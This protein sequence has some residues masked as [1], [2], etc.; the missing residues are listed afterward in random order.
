MQSLKPVDVT[1]YFP[2]V[3]AV[4]AAV[5][6]AAY[7]QIP[8]RLVA[9]A[10]AL[11]ANLPTDSASLLR[12]MHLQALLLLLRDVGPCTDLGTYTSSSLTATFWQQ[13][14]QAG[15]YKLAADSM[16]DTAEQL[17][18]A[19]VFHGASL[20][21]PP[22]FSVS[23]G[24]D[25]GS[26]S[27]MSFNS[28]SSPPFAAGTSSSSSS[29]ANANAAAA[30]GSAGSPGPTPGGK[31]ISVTA[32]S[33]KHFSRTVTLASGLLQLY[34]KL[35]QLCMRQ[36]RETDLEHFMLRVT[37]AACHLIVASMQYISSLQRSTQQ[38]QQ[39]QQEGSAA[40]QEPS[41]ICVD[42]FE[43]CSMVLPLITGTVELADSIEIMQGFYF[44]PFMA[45]A[46]LVHIYAELAQQHTL[47]PAAQAYTASS[48]S[49]SR[50]SKRS[51]EKRRPAASSSTG[52]SSSSSSSL[53]GSQGAAADAAA[54]QH[55]T[56]QA[57]RGVAGQLGRLPVAHAELAALLGCDLGTVVWAGLSLSRVKTDPEWMVMFCQLYYTYLTM[58]DEPFD[59]C[60]LDLHQL[61]PTVLLYWAAHQSGGVY[62]IEVHKVME[63]SYGAFK[64]WLTQSLTIIEQEQGRCSS[65]SS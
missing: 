17:Q 29:S 34:P 8:R 54:K 62:D 32:E 48:S 16:T 36:Q 42:L 18:A 19:A 28:N 25:S 1:M 52:S 7:L 24:L 12:R 5:A 45:I 49:S 43:R 15:L 57:W 61:L 59:S 23:I 46:L 14:C 37:P 2:S 20:L 60:P 21:H 26:G 39:Q 33:M 53:A 38:Q 51:K 50:K 56:L 10:V 64:S 55:I 35:S 41:A 65:S 44:L 47:L 4:T 3:A 6:A 22:D 40:P 11:P 30:A 58:T 27:E 9:S 13:L 31:V 63:G